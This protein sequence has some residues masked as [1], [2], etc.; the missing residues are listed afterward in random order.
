MRT[1]ITGTIHEGNFH[2]LNQI[3][4]DFSSCIR[5][6]YQRIKKYNITDQ[7]EIKNSCKPRYMEKL[8]QRYV[9][10]AVLRA[11]TIEKNRIKREQERKS[12]IKVIFGGK[13]NWKKLQTGSL[14]KEEWHQIR[15]SELYSRGDRTK[16]GNPNI[17]VLSIPEGYKLRIGLGKAR[18][19]ITFNLYIPEKFK[20]TFELNNDCYDVRIKHKN[21]KYYVMI[22]IEIPEITPIYLCQD[23]TIGVDVNPDGLALVEIDLN[24]NLI[25][26]E[27]ISCQRMQFAK[28]NKKK[29]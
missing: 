9:A 13:R 11:Q 28:H 3:M 26:H 17:R 7:N 22:G 5:Y 8:N 18:E 10:D 12:P 16:Q 6:A 25:K 1:I 23:G 4:R 15:D 19:F 24:G 21:S 14:K 29:K 2:V 20:E 27:Y